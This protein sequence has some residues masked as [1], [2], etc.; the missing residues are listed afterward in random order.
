MNKYIILLLCL[1]LGNLYAQAPKPPYK[2][3]KFEQLEQVL[4]TPNE[5][6]TGDGSP[7]YAYWQQRANYK[8]KVAL[9]DN[10]QSLKGSETITYINNSPQDLEY[11]WVQL[12]QNRY[13][14][15]SDTY[16]SETFD[17][18]ER[19]T[20]SLVSYVAGINSD[21]GY[22]VSNVKDAKGKALKYTINKTMMRI[23]L[24][25]TLKAKGGSFTFSLDWT[26]KIVD[27]SK[28]GARGGYE[29]FAEDDNYL[30]EISQWFPR[31]AVYD[32]VNGWQNKQFLGNGEFALTFGD[33]EVEITAPADHIVAATGE[34]QNA[35][36]VLSA[37]QKKR[38]NQAKTAKSPVIIVSQDEVVQ[39]EK[40]K[41]TKTKTWK[42]K[43]ENVRDFA[44]ASSRKFIWDAMQVELEG[45]KVWAMSYYPKEG[46]PLWEKVSTHSIAHTLRVYSK[47]TFDYPYP[48]AI[49]INGPVFGMEY[50]MLSFNGARFCR[51]EGTPQTRKALISVIIHEV[52]HNYFPMIVNSDERQWTWMDEGLNSFLEYLTETEIPG[53]DWAK[54]YYP[55]GSTYPSSRGPAKNIVK[56]MRTDPSQIVPIMNNSESIQQFGNN[57]YGK[58]ATALNILRETIMGKEL[59]DYAFKQYSRKWMFKHP[60]PADFFRTMEDASAVDLDW[61]WRG[62]FYTTEP[63]DIAIEGVELYRMPNASGSS[64]DGAF[65]TKTFQI[66]TPDGLIKRIEENSFKLNDGEKETYTKDKFFYKVKFRNVGGLIMPIIVQFKYKDGSD[67]V[68]RIPAEVWRMDPEIANKVFITDKEIT[69]FVLDPYEETADIDTDNNTFPRDEKQDSKFKEFKEKQ[70]NK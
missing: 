14:K 27:A 4:P 21:G 13:D 18:S 55:A 45:K 67:E 3:S 36:N 15:E 25:E 30:Y 26:H 24:P 44:W 52:G 9:D 19:P 54:E 11:I 6:R 2:S 12:D 57:A 5:F 17:L 53:L 40:T 22:A 31:M 51:G 23:E 50:P 69:G 35:D 16:K 60:M 46:N 65:P 49:S 62:W 68:V 42:F 32:D 61:F 48:V 28:M 33:Y 43:A 64:E 10:T 70:E 59:F 58:P 29:Y 39:K 20:F 66:G 56:Y 37:D 47:Y 7:G 63:C 38:L 41:S 34:L 8:I 1:G